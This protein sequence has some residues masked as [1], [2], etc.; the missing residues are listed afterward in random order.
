MESEVLP[1]LEQF[2][3]TPLVTWVKTCGQMSAQDGNTLSEYTELVDGIYLNKIMDQ[4]NPNPATQDVRKVNSDA[5]QRSQNLSVLVHRIRTYYQETL[6]QLIMMPLPNVMVLGRTPFCEQS[7]DEMRRLLLL[8]LGCAVQCEKKEDYIEKIQTLEFD[9]KAAIASHIQEVTHSQENVFDLHWLDVS[10]LCPEEL[11]SMSRTM[12]VHLSHLLDQRDKQLETIMELTQERESVQTA[13]FASDEPT[14]PAESSRAHQS[15]SHQQLAVE[16]ADSKARIRRLR[17]ELEEKSEQ[18]LDCRQELDNMGVEFKRIQQ[19]NV[20]LLSDARAVRTYRDELDALREK[21]LKADKLESEVG[22]YRDKLHNMEFYRAKVEELK[23]DNQVLLETKSMLE[24]QLESSRAR[25]EKSHHLEKHTL[26]LQARLHDMEEERALD[27]RRI[28]ELLEE[29]VALELAQRRT[30]DESLHLGWELEQLS[31]DP[32]TTSPTEQKSLDQEVTESTCSRLLRLEQE[33]RSLL[34][35]LQELRRARSP[36][37]GGRNTSLTQEVRNTTISVCYSSQTSPNTHALQEEQQMIAFTKRISCPESNLQALKAENQKLSQML[38]DMNRKVQNLEA[39]LQDL[40]AEN[41]SLQGNVEELRISS[42]RLEQLE[43]ENRA[44]EQENSQ[45]ERD[46]GRLEKEN[47]RLRQRAEIQEATLDSSSLR[48]AGLEKENRALA[49]EVATLRETHTRTKELET[50]NKELLKQAAIDKRTLATLREELVSER[51]KTQQRENDLEKL[52]H[53]LDRMGL[54]Q[55]R[56]L[57]DQETADHSRFKM[58]EMELESSLKRSLEIKEEKIAALEARLQESSSLNQQLRHELKTV[59]QNYEALLQREEEERA[60]GTSPPQAVREWQKESQETTRELLRVKD[61]LIEVERNNATLQA[62]RQSLHTQLKQV[63]AQSGGLNAQIVALQRQTASLQESNTAL[64]TQNAQLQV[65]KSALNSQS[66]SLMAQN[67]QLQRLQ[68]SAEG[69]KESAVRDRDDLRTVNE[70]LLRDHER[71]TALHEKQAAEYEALINKHADLKTSHRSLEL[72]HRSL[73]DRYNTLLQQKAQLEGLQKVLREEQERMQQVT[74][75]HREAA[76]ECQRLR[77]EKDWLNQ[78]YQKLLTDN[79]VLQADHKNLKSVLNCI[80][81]EQTRLESELSQLKEQY[82]QLDISCTKLTNQCELLTQLKGNLEEENRHLLDQIQS[83]ML[84]NRTLLEQTMESK[85]LFHVEQRQYI[86]KLNE[87]RR[88]KEK[89]EEKIMDQYKFY[90][91]SPPR[92][93]GNWIALKMKKLMKS[94]SRERVRSLTPPARSESC[95]GLPELHCHDNGSFVGSQGS[96]ES[97]S[98]SL[99]DD[100]LS[101]KRSSTLKMFRVIR[102]KPREKDKV[103]SFFRRS[104]SLNDLHH[105]AEG[106]SDGDLH[107]HAEGHLDGDLKPLEGQTEWDERSELQTSSFSHTTKMSMNHPPSSVNHLHRSTDDPKPRVRAKGKESRTETPPS[108]PR[109]NHQVQDA[110]EAD[111]LESRAQ[112]ESSGEFSLSAENEAWSNGSSPIQEPPS[113]RPSDPSPPDRPPPKD[114]GKRQGSCSSGHGLW[115]SNTVRA[116]AG[117]GAERRKELRKTESVRVY[118]SSPKILLQTQSKSSSISGCLD[119]FA[120]PLRREGRAG[121]IEMPATLPRASSV[122]STSE[123]ASRRASFHSTGSGR[124]V[125]PSPSKCCR[126]SQ[127]LEVPVPLNEFPGKVVADGCPLVEEEPLFGTT[128]TIDSVFTDTIFSEHVRCGH[129]DQ[130]VLCLN[131]SLVHNITAMPAKLGPH[132]TTVLHDGVSKSQNGGPCSGQQDDLTIKDFTTAN[133]KTVSDQCV[134]PSSEN[135]QSVVA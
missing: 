72:E 132:E 115:R 24:E 21:A 44:M 33:N 31:K 123:G 96:V 133:H 28:E 120:T 7:L 118:S 121:A 57:G 40:E 17:Q 66:A 84:Q 88:Q 75:E 23:E 73:E 117:Q 130:T 134:N 37:E 105:H 16:L 79:E 77:D 91:P 42:R 62:E 22:R 107:H 85:D 65:E 108:G 125:A 35:T 71:L 34:K 113:R 15:V 45:L 127:G 60:G 29:N 89:L 114:A 67:S 58:L 110:A 111:G 100:A 63:Q 98:N 116:A 39:Q 12:A 19:E 87:L 124:S 50:E 112:S 43:T 56:L 86:D 5:V 109:D 81:L 99:H 128:F 64:Q 95:E 76:A 93:R 126:G 59:K 53:E 8:L 18:L 36:S 103:R 119:C 3:L 52:T 2:M 41:Q 26:Q 47:R 104:L 9:T 101:P 80:K 106:H 61:R 20:L 27:K 69:E 51:L 10:D 74:K 92:R 94:R 54:N 70:L 83:L 4:I 78:T 129:N 131:T 135:K 38:E 25:S 13:E 46:K 97:G 11:V 122:I 49:K 48:Q 14:T 102:G 32:Q 82:Q 55:E 90:D 30:L 6:R 68:F 1:I